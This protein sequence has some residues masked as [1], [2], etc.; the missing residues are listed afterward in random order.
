MSPVSRGRGKKNRSVKGPRS[1][2]APGRRQA[3]QPGGGA[4]QAVSWPGPEFP[5]GRLG[6]DSAHGWP[7]S[8]PDAIRELA[9]GLPGAGE[10][11]A[12]ART[13]WPS[14]H[15]EVLESAAG[16]AGCTDPAELEDA[17]CDVLG[18]HWQRMRQ[19]HKT[20][21][22]ADEWL[23]ELL[24]AAEPR[25]GEP[26]VRRL[27]YGI[28]AIAAP[29]LAGVAAELL[30]APAA[31]AGDPAWLATPPAVTASPDVLVLRD[32]YGMRYG[33]L[34]EVSGAGGPRGTYLFDIDLCHGY[35]QVLTSGYHASTAAAAAAWRDLAGASAADSEPLPAPAELLPHILPGGGVIDGLIGQPLTDGH[36][37]ELYRGNR[38]VHAIAEA[39][40]AAGRPVAWPQETPELRS[41]RAGELTRQFRA[42]AGAAGVSLPPASE[43]EDAGAGEADSDD[44]D[45]GEGDIVEW[46]LDDWHT[47]DLPGDLALG[48]SPHR[49]AA[50]TAY[51]NDD[52]LPAQRQ[53]ALP[54][55]HPLARF[56]LESTGVTGEAA[57]RTLTMARRAADDP[58]AVGADF[59]NHLN[60]PVDETTLVTDPL[61]DHCR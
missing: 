36:F 42:W 40:D 6:R 24:D 16:L 17:V 2:R 46:L 29:G 61:P 48:C 9:L 1:K 34:A 37:T 18:R 43:G 35:Y 28:A 15:A 53:R 55:L 58:A 33:L 57:D 60:L 21:F 52:W 45:D 49:I 13:W 10:L 41:A 44:E 26:G 11:Q 25:A 7:G 27:L 32:G 50:F 22:R 14:S 47:S 56:C 39:L 4:A 12:A 31:R 30:Q 51:L 3:A 19:R 8:V 38:I 59:G 23:E 54:L 20:G 5:V